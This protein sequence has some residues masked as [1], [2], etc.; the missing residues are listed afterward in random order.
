VVGF[1]CGVFLISIESVKRLV[2]PTTQVE[3]AKKDF[4][5]LS[6]PHADTGTCQSGT[7]LGHEKTL[8]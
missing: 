8:L 7:W 5:L 4:A 1:F 6:W 3:P 2:S